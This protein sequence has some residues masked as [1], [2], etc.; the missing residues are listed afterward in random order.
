MIAYKI[1][2]T[3]NG[4]GYIGITCLTLKKRWQ[5]HCHRSK[6]G[7][8]V[9]CRALRKYGVENFRIEEIARAA[10]IKELRILE[11]ALIAEHGTYVRTGAGYNK[12]IGGDGGVPGR[13]A[14]P[15]EIERTRRIWL[16]KNLPDHMKQKISA[17]LKGRYMSPETRAKIADANRGK[18]VTEETRRRISLANRGRKDNIETRVKKSISAKGKPKSPEH[19]A[20]MSAAARSA[21]PDA[22]ARRGA[23]IRAAYARKRAKDNLQQAGSLPSF[24]DGCSPDARGLS[25]FSS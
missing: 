14:T 11:R 24:A 5:L 12:T 20:A 17:T 10:S 22:R 25:A 1:T 9:I 6:T 7:V 15:E 19:R 16:G 13:K 18:H 23:A 3:I 4:K 2:N 8:E 21:P